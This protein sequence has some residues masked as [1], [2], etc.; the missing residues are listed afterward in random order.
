VDRA[1]VVQSAGFAIDPACDAPND[2]D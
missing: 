2:R 1:G